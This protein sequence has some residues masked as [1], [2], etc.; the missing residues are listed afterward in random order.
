M[1]SLITWKHEFVWLHRI[2]RTL[3][4]ICSTWSCWLS[5]LL[6]WAYWHHPFKRFRVSFN[7]FIL[8]NKIKSDSRSETQL[9]ARKYQISESNQWNVIFRC[10]ALDSI[11]EPTAVD[12]THVITDVQLKITVLWAKRSA[13]TDAQNNKPCRN[14]CKNEHLQSAQISFIMFLNKNA[15]IWGK[16]SPKICCLHDLSHL[17][18]IYPIG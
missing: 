10:H 9:I 5:S 7:T 3:N 11:Q 12:S 13:I 18:K 6:Y 17:T 14:P 15:F 4:S 16:I 2:I 8:R 1:N